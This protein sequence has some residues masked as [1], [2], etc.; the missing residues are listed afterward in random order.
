MP[1]TLECRRCGM[2]LGEMEKGRLRNGA[3]LLCQ[4]CWENASIAIGMAELASENGRKPFPKEDG[5]VDDLMGM[6]GMKR[7]ARK[8]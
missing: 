4:G 3:A 1:K 6:F 7:K 2:F 8:T 5:V